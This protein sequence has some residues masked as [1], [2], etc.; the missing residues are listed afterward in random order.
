V[1]KKKHKQKAAEKQKKN[2]AKQRDYKELKPYQFKPGQSGNPK[3]T[4]KSRTNL[5]RYFCQY[6][7][8]SLAELTRIK[9][10]KGLPTSKRA[11]LILAEK[12]AKGE[13]TG[14]QRLARYII[15]REEGKPTEYLVV[16]G[17]DNA[18]THEKCDE[19]RKVLQKRC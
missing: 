12:F 3:G 14:S 15:D 5:W 6:M 10:Q 7:D 4:P 19:I 8:M 2:T 17:N 1:V 16:G 11:A 18:M 9:R 13:Y